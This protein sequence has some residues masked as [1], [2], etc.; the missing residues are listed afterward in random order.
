MPIVIKPPL[1]DKDINKLKAGD[2]VLI[3]GT[4]YT[5]R[6]AAHK[7]FGDKP[8]FDIK[9]AVIYYASPTPTPPG[10]VIGSIGP[11]TS[12]RMDAFAPALL[13]KGLKVMIGKGR[14]GQE[15][16]DAMKKY[17]AVYLVV[18]GGTAALLSKQVK[19]AKVLAYP[20]LGAEAVHEL[21]SPTSPQSSPST[22]KEMTFLIN[23]QDTRNNNQKMI[24]EQ[25]P[26]TKWLTKWPGYW[27]L[28]FGFFLVLVSWLLVIPAS[29]KEYDG[30][31]FLG[32]NVQ[33][34]PFD[35]LK[36][37]QAVAHALNAAAGSD[38]ALP[39][40]FVPPTMTGADPDLK[41]F[42]ANIPFARTL[43]KR[44]GYKPNDPRLKKVRLLHTDGDKT[45]VIARQIKQDLK[46]IGIGVELV[47]VS[48]R[49]EVR[50]S[51]EL[52][53]HKYPLFLMGYKADNLF[54]AEAA[55]AAPDTARLLE[56]LFR[57]NGEANFTGYSN[58]DV[59]MLFDQLS[60]IN[61]ALEGERELKLK[62][63]GK[64]YLS[65]P[66]RSRPVLYRTDMKDSINY[67][68]KVKKEDIYAICPFFEAF[69]GMA[70]IRTPRPESGPTPH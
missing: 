24:N 55:T 21:R 37:R 48:Y 15:V 12:S 49:D 42:K 58:P 67:F 22:P 16:I 70:A 66:S 11:T 8:P 35:D 64:A 43:L 53:S 25:I 10:K 51:R 18:P 29:A 13:K 30:I 65:R 50:W 32:F 34:P 26:I 33:K 52:A 57:T 59:D 60:V 68:F 1:S 69:E 39:A 56:P 6:D 5:A 7:K 40:G 28:K 27:M 46:K 45:V 19:K 61:P 4:I 20:E 31:W 23:N 17:G 47:E 38:E 2:R 41:P 3:S 14:R 62:E 54:T 63:V 9:G 44:A 36:V